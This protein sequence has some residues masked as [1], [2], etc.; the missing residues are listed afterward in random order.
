MGSRTKIMPQRHRDNP[1]DFTSRVIQLYQALDDSLYGNN[2]LSSSGM[3]HPSHTVAQHLNHDSL[4]ESSTANVFVSL[5][6]WARL[7]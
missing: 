6:I 7:C 3:F 1:V 2:T 4:V 5:M